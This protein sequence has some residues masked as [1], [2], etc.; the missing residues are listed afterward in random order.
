MK[1]DFVQEA[2]EKANKMPLRSVME[3][4][5]RLLPFTIES[6]TSKSFLFHRRSLLIE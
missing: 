1:D 4:E 2:E 3:Q 5:N 6:R